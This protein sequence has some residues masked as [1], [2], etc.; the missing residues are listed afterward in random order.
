MHSLIQNKLWMRNLPGQFNI[1]MVEKDVP[2]NKL[3]K[4]F[5]LI[6][7]GTILIH[8]ESVSGDLNE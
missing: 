8:F 5:D 4:M 1:F 6:S 7:A 3:G 2:F